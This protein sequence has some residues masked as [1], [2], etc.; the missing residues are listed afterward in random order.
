MDEQTETIIDNLVDTLFNLG[1]CPIKGNPAID[2]DGWDYFS[3]YIDLVD[4]WYDNGYCN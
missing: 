4:Y 2:D 1:L 3:L